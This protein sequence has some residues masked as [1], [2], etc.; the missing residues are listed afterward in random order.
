[1]QAAIARFESMHGAIVTQEK[2]KEKSKSRTATPQQ[3]K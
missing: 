1:L 3:L 2:K